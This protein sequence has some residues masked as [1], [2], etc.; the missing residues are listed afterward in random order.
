MQKRRS[1][2][3]CCTLRFHAKRPGRYEVQTKTPDTFRSLA[4]SSRQSRSQSDIVSP[5]PFRLHLQLSSAISSPAVPSTNFRLPSASSLSRCFRST[6]DF[7]L[8]PIS[9][10]A[11]EF[12]PA[13]AGPPSSVLPSTSV[14]LA[15]PI[16]LQPLRSTF[17]RLPPAINLLR[18]P[19]PTSDSRRVINFRWCPRLTSD[20]HQSFESG[21]AFRP[22]LGLR[23]ALDPSRSTFFSGRLTAVSSVERTIRIG[24]LC[25]QV[26]NCQVM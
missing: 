13:C 19:P 16:H 15:P 3:C 4:S 12:L 1:R 8:T 2:L 26:Q 11:V 24:D 20:L 6:P 9:C 10:A 5:S 18:H 22:T 17:S 7:R 21:F 25:T 14:R 23:L